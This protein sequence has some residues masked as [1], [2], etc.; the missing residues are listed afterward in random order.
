LIIACYFISCGFIDVC[1][2]SHDVLVYC[3]RIVQ[4]IIN[5]FDSTLILLHN[6]LLSLEFLKSQF[7]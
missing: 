3:V 2:E 1:V 7:L 6:V 4:Y 5:Y